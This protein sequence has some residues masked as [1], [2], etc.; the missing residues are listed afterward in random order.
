MG[1]LCLVNHWWEPLLI[2]EGGRKVIA[3]YICRVSTKTKQDFLAAL[4]HH[5]DKMIEAVI[6][7]DEPEIVVKV[8]DEGMKIVEHNPKNELRAEQRRRYKELRGE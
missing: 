3:G 8:I 1:L 7:K 4:T 6:G 2:K 5:I